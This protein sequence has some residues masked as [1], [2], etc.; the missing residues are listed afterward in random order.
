M[1]HRKFIERRPKFWAGGFLFD[2]QARKVL[3]HLRDDQTIFN[4]SRWAF[5]GGLNEGSESFGECLVRELHEEIALQVEPDRVIYLRDYA[6]TTLAQHRAV[7]YVL[8]AVPPEHLVLGEGA[9]LA[10]IALDEI[11]KFDLTE[12]TRQDLEYFVAHLSDSR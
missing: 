8:S 12:A 10:W 7:F 9:G 5:L 2:A 6:R 11:A 4:P 1:P 3:L